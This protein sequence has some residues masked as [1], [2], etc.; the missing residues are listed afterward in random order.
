[1][2]ER[3]QELAAIAPDVCRYYP[4]DNSYVIGAYRFWQNDFG[5]VG[6]TM[7]QRIAGRPALAW[8]RDALEAV[9]EGRGWETFSH[10]ERGQH[11]TRVVID[12]RPKRFVSDWQTTAAEALLVAL[13]AA[14]KER[15]ER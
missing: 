4:S 10:Q 12:E 5:L 14:L 11:Y 2:I 15:E 6:Q 9:I 13:C 3:L 8:L 1:M 7:G